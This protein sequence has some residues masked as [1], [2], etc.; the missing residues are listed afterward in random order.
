M[1]GGDFGL[2]TKYTRHACGLPALPNPASQASQV[3]A[4][5][6][7]VQHAHESLLL[8]G[9]QSGDPIKADE[10]TYRVVDVRALRKILDLRENCLTRAN[11][12]YVDCRE[13]V[14]QLRVKK[15]DVYDRLVARPTWRETGTGRKQE[16]VGP[17]Y[18]VILSK[19]NVRSMALPLC[20]YEDVTAHETYT[21]RS[22]VRHVESLKDLMNVFISF[23]N[24]CATA[25]KGRGK[26]S[27]AHKHWKDLSASMNSSLKCLEE[28]TGK[29]ET[30]PGKRQRVLTKRSSQ[31]TASQG[32]DSVSQDVKYHVGPEGV[33]GRLYATGFGAQAL[34]T[35]I[36][37]ILLSDTL[38]LDIRNC[39]FTLVVQMIEFMELDSA[40][41]DAVKPE[42]DALREMAY[43]R[44]ECHRVEL[45]MALVEWKEMT[46]EIFNGAKVPDDLLA[47]IFVANLSSAGRFCRFLAMS[48]LPDVYDTVKRDKSKDFPEATVMAYWWQAVESTCL[49]H[50]MK[51]VASGVYDHLSLAH[52][53]LRIS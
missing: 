7:D 36:Q 32:I 11:F 52:D 30:S 14:V 47:N 1:R 49:L 44:G 53:G 22:G 42:L 10:K 50:M 16:E 21:F 26:P 8:L 40:V 46:V 2:T 35:W 17:Q 4:S 18:P 41:L 48:Q 34:P 28:I 24:A 20:D 31:E 3:G 29:W 5:Q 38:D 25:T 33:Q 12:R 37:E 6:P 15:P 23:F 39:V 27:A 19:T 45:G 9:T 51:Y 43:T 13:L